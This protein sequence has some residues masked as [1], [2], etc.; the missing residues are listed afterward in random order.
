MKRITFLRDENLKKYK[1]IFLTRY[2]CIEFELFENEFLVYFPYDK[3]YNGQSTKEM[4]CHWCLMRF[5][6]IN[7]IEAVKTSF[8]SYSLI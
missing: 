3:Y 5:W 4:S 8:E 7:G 1:T 2:F 6:L